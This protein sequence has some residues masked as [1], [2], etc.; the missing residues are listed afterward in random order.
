ME[1][2][3]L[4]RLI[5]GLLA[6]VCAFAAAMA[7]AEDR[8]TAR[9][10]LGVTPYLSTRTLIPIHKPL[11]QHLKES[12]ETVTE[13]YTAADFR[14]FF[15]GAIQGEYDLVIMPSHF[16]RLAQRDHGFIPLVRYS[17]G[18]R[19]MLMTAKTGGVDKLEAL[20]GQTVAVADRLA[21]A[22]IV[23]LGK[24]KEKGLQPD[25]DFHI[26]LTASFNSAMIAMEK[27]EAAAAVSTPGA[28]AQMPAELRESARPLLDT[29]EY[30][31]L[32]YLAHPGLPEKVRSRVKSTLFEFGRTAAGKQFLADTGSG[33]FVEVGSED[34][35][36]LDTHL[37]ET[38]RLLLAR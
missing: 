7:S 32:V 1:S 28:L 22:A 3:I 11:Q 14:S 29:G 15:N 38:K 37:A 35:R 23:V 25:V 12:L 33:E 13:V 9:L 36:A 10:V 21:L 30:V 8:T 4:S 34:L 20:R 31:S 2:G 6:L 16:A 27:G 26:S 18:G 5:A 24:M 19:G 17:R